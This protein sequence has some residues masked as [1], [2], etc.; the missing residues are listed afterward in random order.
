[1]ARLHQQSKA[2]QRAWVREDNA[3]AR[4]FKARQAL[5]KALLAQS[6][7]T[8]ARKEAETKAAK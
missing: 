8:S 3:K 4:V 7:A 1:M 2:V 5:G 6:K